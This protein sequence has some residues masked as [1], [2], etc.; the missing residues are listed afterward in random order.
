MRKVQEVIPTIV[1]LIGNTKQ[2]TM[3]RWACYL[4]ATAVSSS[5][6]T[7]QAFVGTVLWTIWVCS[8]FMTRES[9]GL[10]VFKGGGLLRLTENLRGGIY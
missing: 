2:P 1:V 10:E 4:T 5:Q 9:D 6:A 8:E 3:S 7:L